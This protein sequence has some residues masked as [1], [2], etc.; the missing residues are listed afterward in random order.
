M[1]T[2]TKNKSFKSTLRILFLSALI[3]CG[4]LSQATAQKLTYNPKKTDNG[5]IFGSFTFPKKKPDLMAILC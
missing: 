5:L 1:K 2:T 3:F 4:A